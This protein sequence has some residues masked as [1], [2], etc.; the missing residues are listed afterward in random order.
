MGREK[1][2]RE[3]RREKEWKLIK[4]GLLSFGSVSQRNKTFTRPTRD[5]GVDIQIQAILALIS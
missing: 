5:G 3:T 2:V 4:K 1:N